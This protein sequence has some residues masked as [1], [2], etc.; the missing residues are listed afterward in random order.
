MC[1]FSPMSPGSWIARLFGAGRVHVSN[2]NIFARFEDAGTQIL[3]YAMTL[4]ARA[5]VAMI[6]PVPTPPAADEDALAFIDLHEYP[7]FFSELAMLF[8]MPMVAAV[9]SARA[10]PLRARQRTLQVHRVG[11]FVASFVPSLADFGRLEARFRLP[12]AVWDAVPGVRDFGFA[13]FQLEAGAQQL[14][15]MA[16]RFQTRDPKRLFFPTL[17]VH[18]CRVHPRARFDHALYYQLAE[19]PTIT[20]AELATSRPRTDYGGV[21][22]RSLPTLRRKLRGRRPNRDTYVEL[23]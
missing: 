19:R 16:F 11:S 13:V 22:D 18:D 12:D 23:G 20:D 5:E 14:H 2:T 10:M 4:S 3:V 17:H 15:P 1:C 7:H 8:E 6:L 9:K 21:V